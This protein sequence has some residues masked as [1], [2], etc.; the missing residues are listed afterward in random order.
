[1]APQYFSPFPYHNIRTPEL[2][3]AIA[4]LFGFSEKQMTRWILH[5]K[6]LLENMPMKDKEES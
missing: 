2:S 1:M 5:A 3:W 4:D 6:D